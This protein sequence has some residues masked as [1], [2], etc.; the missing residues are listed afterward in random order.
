MGSERKS[1][2]GPPPPVTRGRFPG[3]LLGYWFYVRRR[4][5]F[6]LVL[7]NP[8]TVRMPPL[9]YAAAVGCAGESG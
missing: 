2:G 3:T 5:V 1:G 8:G 6:G 9:R 4:W 7:S